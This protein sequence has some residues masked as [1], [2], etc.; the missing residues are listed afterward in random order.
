MFKRLL[1]K[2]PQQTPR[3]VIAHGHIFKNAGSTLDWALKRNFGREFLDHRD[4][5]PMREQGA[6]YLEKFLD[7]HPALKAI[8]S[9]HLCYPLPTSDRLKVIPLYLLRQPIERVLSVYEFERRQRGNTPGAINAKK[10]DIRDYVR[11]RLAPESGATIRDYHV[12]YLTGMHR[13]PRREIHLEIYEQALANVR[14]GSLLGLVEHLD[15][16]FVE[17]E[18][19]LRHRGVAELD[20]AYVPQN[21][22]AERPPT[23]EERVATLRERLGTELFEE[24]EAANAWDLKLHALVDAEM[25]ARRCGNADLEAQL[26]EFSKRCVKLS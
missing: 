12:R 1:R 2:P 23:S 5:A 7:E 10:M 22:N 13:F 25:T 14:S 21:V 8:S 9:H 24:L 19:A 6:P 20:L 16:S 11:W 3:V 26:H 15:Q 4:D 17:F 18:Q